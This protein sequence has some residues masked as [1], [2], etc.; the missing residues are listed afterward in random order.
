MS[1]RPMIFRIWSW[2]WRKKRRKTA[3]YKIGLTSP[4]KIKQLNIDQPFMPTSLSIWFLM[5]ANLVDGTV[6]SPAYWAGSDHCLEGG[7]L[8]RECDFEE[9]M[10]KI[11]YV[12][13]SVEIDSLSRFLTLKMWLLITPL[14]GIYPIPIAWPSGYLEW[15]G[16]RLYQWWE[17]WWRVGRCSQPSS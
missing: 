5:T 4:A 2:L 17:D 3:A 15:E 8:P 1:R 11:D 7:Y 10:D 13:S 16:C 12:Y 6:Y 14:G 9:V